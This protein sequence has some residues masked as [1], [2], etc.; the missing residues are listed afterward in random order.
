[1]PACIPRTP[2]LLTEAGE[3]SDPF[4]LQYVAGHD[5]IKTAMRCVHS[6]EHAIQELFVQLGGRERLKAG[7]ECKKSVKNRRSAKCPRKPT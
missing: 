3:Y 7:V 2:T 5:N 6:R 1:M 4:T